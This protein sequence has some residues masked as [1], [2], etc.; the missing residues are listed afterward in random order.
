LDIFEETEKFG[1]MDALTLRKNTSER[2]RAYDT[3][4]KGIAAQT[5]NPWF[6]AGKTILTSLATSKALSSFGGGSA[7]KTSTTFK[8]GKSPVGDWNINPKYIGAA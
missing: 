1:R 5:Q 2:M 3:Q 7:G 6:N 8:G 4:I